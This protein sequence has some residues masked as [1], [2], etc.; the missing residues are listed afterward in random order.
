MKNQKFELQ[1]KLYQFPYH[2]IP[3]LENGVVALHRE[4]QWGLDYLSY[5]NFVAELIAEKIKPAQM[6]DVG[7]GDG[8]LTHMLRDRVPRIVGVDLATT[9]ISLARALNPGSE[10]M[11][12]DLKNVSEKFSLATLIEVMEHIPDDGY[13]DFIRSVA[14]VLEPRGLLVV[15]VPTVNIPLNAKHYRH[16]DLQLLTQQLSSHFTIKSHWYISRHNFAAAVV[17]NLL[18]NRLVI[19][20]PRFWRRFVWWLHHALC[21]HATP[22]SGAH[23]VAVAELKSDC[24]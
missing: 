21:L 16:Y 9:A 10:F 15:S 23:L 13:P 8:R 12:D 6:I 18:T 19:V 5:M 20:K 14:G 22:T 3:Y 4:L 1:E 7:C 17:R 2:Y 11:A 24:A